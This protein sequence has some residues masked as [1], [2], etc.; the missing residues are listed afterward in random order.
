MNSHLTVPLSHHLH[1][2]RSSVWLCLTLLLLLTILFA[3]TPF[4]RTTFA[5]QTQSLLMLGGSAIPQDGSPGVPPFTTNRLALE[6][7]D[8]AT[9]PSDRSLNAYLLKGETNTGLLCHNLP[10]SNGFVSTNCDFPDQNLIRYDT[11]ALV[12]ETTVFSATLPRGALRYLR[13]VLAEAGDS[14]N[15]VGYG[16]G[17]RTEAEL[18]AKHAAFAQDSADS[19]NLSAAKRHAEHALNILYGESDARYGDHDNDGVVAN[20]GDGF[21][22]LTYRAKLYEHMQF[23]VEAGDV[24]PNIRTRA[25]EVQT[26]LNN[27]GGGNG[28]GGWADVFIEKAEALLVENDNSTVQTLAIQ[29]AGMAARINRGEEL[30]DNGEI[31]PIAG[32]GGAQT[33]WRRTQMAADYLT[34][35]GSSYVRLVDSS[36]SISNDSLRIRLTGLPSANAGEEIWVYLLGDSGD[37]YLAGSVDGSSGAIDVTVPGSG[38]NLALGFRAARLTLGYKIAEDRLPAALHWAISA[39]P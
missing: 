13:Q 38:R 29:M 1:R 22:L 35:D 24:T 17:L 34:S 2:C 39:P 4:S 33:A 12:Q 11:L 3:G 21:G 18:L 5:L 28:D 37:Y 15:N 23:A 36:G 19:G 7:T 16:V 8:V 30:N 31:E 10:V 20:P 9:P 27:I 32:E 26:A 6:F 25:A 14:P